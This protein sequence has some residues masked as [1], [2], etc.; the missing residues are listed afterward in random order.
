M[1]PNSYHLLMELMSLNGR[2]AEA[3]SLQYKLPEDNETQSV[4]EA[5]IKRLRKQRDLIS[6]DFHHKMECE[7][8]FQDLRGDL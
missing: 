4:L 3:E 5:D 8:G 2:I 1:S 7:I 6:R